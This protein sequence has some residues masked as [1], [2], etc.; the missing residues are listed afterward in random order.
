MQGHTLTAHAGV[1][2]HPHA[3]S[4]RHTVE[5]RVGRGKKRKHSRCAVGV[6]TSN[7]ATQTADGYAAS[8]R[9]E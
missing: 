2:K 1:A 4:F 5:Q 8:W 7:A 3:V 9:S 6:Y